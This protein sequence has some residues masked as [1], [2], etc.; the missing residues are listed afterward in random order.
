M[1][2]TGVALGEMRR[3]R[4]DGL[5]Q[6]LRGRC[7]QDDVGAG[8]KGDIGGHADARIQTHAGQFRICFAVAAICAARAASRA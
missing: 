8:G 5:A 1:A 7:D 4:G 2:I 3:Q 6:I